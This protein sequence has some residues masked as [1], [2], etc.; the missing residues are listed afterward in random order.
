MLCSNTN[1]LRSF[2]G[3]TRCATRVLAVTLA[4]L[5]AVAAHANDG[6]DTDFGFL[7]TNE[8]NLSSYDSVDGL[9]TDG[10]GR[11]YVVGGTLKDVLSDPAGGGHIPDQ[12][13]QYIARFNSDGTKDLTFGGFGGAPAGA[14][15]LD[16]QL[17]GGVIY[18]VTTLADD[19]LM[20]VGMMYEQGNGTLVVSRHLENGWLDESFGNLGKQLIPMPVVGYNGT[21]K[22]VNDKV[23]VW[24]SYFIA[25]L[26]LDGTLDAGFGGDGV[27]VVATDIGASNYIGDLKF[28]NDSL[29]IATLSKGVPDQRLRLWQIDANGNTVGGFGVGGTI[30]LSAWVGPHQENV[31]IGVRD[32]MITVGVN[33][34][35]LRMD[36]AGNYDPTFGETGFKYVAGYG[37]ILSIIHQ[38]Y[39]LTT[40]CFRFTLPSDAN[41]FGVGRILSDGSRD[42]DFGNGNAASEAGWLRLPYGQ[43]PYAENLIGYTNGKVLVAGHY[44]TMPGDV[45]NIAIFRTEEF[46]VQPAN[47]W[48]DELDGL[49]VEEPDNPELPSVG[50]KLV[51]EQE[52]L[53]D[54]I[55]EADVDQLLGL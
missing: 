26:N 35:M 15:V 36:F 5:L 51:L 28:S 50:Q 17:S 6:L 18:G 20:S 44:T 11:I 39:G 13:N 9:S 30:N 33:N 7:G 43:L 49:Q 47:P 14:V 16:F 25:R 19:K 27:V 12:S 37:R 3:R 40:F 45:R 21:M 46:N 54:P 42:L 31:A 1:V 4:G 32:E 38:P 53:D 55:F 34:W 22:R 52:P 24:N 8:L 41:K 23:Y 48:S 2:V 10:T 29:I